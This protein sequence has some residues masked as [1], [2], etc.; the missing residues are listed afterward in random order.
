[1]QALRDAGV[2]GAG[3]D[4]WLSPELAAAEQLVRSGALVT[5]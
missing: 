4:R 3:S 2:P 5:T 1:V